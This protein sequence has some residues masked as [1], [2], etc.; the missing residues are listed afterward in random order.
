MCWNYDFNTTVAPCKSQIL[1]D[2]TMFEDNGLPL[3]ISDIW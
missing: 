1:T 3:N 2:A